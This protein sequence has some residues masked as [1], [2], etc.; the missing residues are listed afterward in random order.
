MRLL[1]LGTLLAAIVVGGC[2]LSTTA[3]P[4]P[5]RATPVAD[6][7]LRAKVVWDGSYQRDIQPIF[8]AYCVQC[9]R[10]GRAENGLRLD[11]Y[12]GTMKGT[13]FGAVVVPGSAT[14]ST[15]VAVIQGTASL[16]IRMPHEERQLSPNRI[17][18]VVLWIEAGAPKD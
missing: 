12:E 4:V 3:T 6:V 9:H 14:R 5:S 8:N 11:T 2:T 18:N 13:Q 7:P 15:L 17:Q 16:E 1:A 10:P